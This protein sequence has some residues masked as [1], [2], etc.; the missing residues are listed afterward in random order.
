MKQNVASFICPER[1][2]QLL[3]RRILKI[4]LNQS[5]DPYVVAVMSNYKK[6][7]QKRFG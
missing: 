6:T 5:I 3:L 7:I 1:L 4:Y 2:K